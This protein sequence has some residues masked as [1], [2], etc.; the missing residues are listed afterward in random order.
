MAKSNYETANQYYLRAG[1][2]ING[3]DFS[4][5]IRDT[6][7]SNEIKKMA[8]IK[9]VNNVSA[10]KV[11]IPEEGENKTKRI[12]YLR[13]GDTILKALQNKFGTNLDN[14]I[15]AN[16][17]IISFS[18]WIHP[19][20]SATRD[21]TDPKYGVP[22]T[23][24]ENY[25][26]LVFNKEGILINPTSESFVICCGGMVNIFIKNCVIWGS[27]NTLE[28]ADKVN[29]LVLNMHKN[30][31]KVNG[32]IPFINENEEIEGYNKLLSAVIAEDG[33]DY[34][35]S[36]IYL[37]ANEHF[38]K[39]PNSFYDLI[40]RVSNLNEITEADI[41]DSWASPE[42]KSLIVR[43]V[44]TILSE[45]G[46]V[47]FVIPNDNEEKYTIN[48]EKFFE[49]K[50]TSVEDLD[51]SFDIQTEIQDPEG[52][53]YKYTYT[54][55]TLPN[56]T[57]FYVQN[58]ACPFSEEIFIIKNKEDEV[59]VKGKFRAYFTNNSPAYGPTVFNKSIGA[60]FD[61]PLGH[62]D[63]TINGTEEGDRT[64]GLTY[65]DYW[66]HYYP[67]G[68]IKAEDVLV[69]I[70]GIKLT[71]YVNYDIGYAKFGQET[72]SPVI[73]FMID[74]MDTDSYNLINREEYFDSEYD[75]TQVN[76]EYLSEYAT[77]FPIPTEVGHP[78]WIKVVVLPPS[79]ELADYIGPTVAEEGENASNR[80]IF[81]NKGS[82]STVY[83][84]TVEQ[85]AREAS[86]A[87]D[88]A[89]IPYEG[90]I[91][92]QGGKYVANEKEYQKRIIL[93][94]RLYVNPAYTDSQYD[95][96][97]HVV[98]DQCDDHGL[99][100]LITSFDTDGN[101]T[102]ASILSVL[103]AE[104]NVYVTKWLAKMK[105]VEEDFVDEIVNTSGD[106]LTAQ[107]LLV[108]LGLVL[109]SPIEKYI[110]A[111]TITETYTESTTGQPVRYP[112]ISAEFSANEDLTQLGYIGD[113]VVSGSNC[114][115]LASDFETNNTGDEV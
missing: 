110:A 90:F 55:K 12:L 47:N 112:T 49:F 32:S 103:G 41:K 42:Q 18:Q 71:P 11:Y 92:F 37:N 52:K 45:R 40:L 27:S 30:Q 106:M 57:R 9:K 26:Y 36:G 83:Y 56:G 70:N 39:Y 61:I 81:K 20:Y 63:S 46:H 50:S 105:S 22:T 80:I 100:S 17:A 60:L 89:H 79:G 48:E 75:T 69:F 74:H 73:R 35:P 38:S 6:R 64:D 51:L 111:N 24:T 54:L 65:K 114:P 66:K 8:I 87:I 82:N 99:G 16:T 84:P 68:N 31:W 97:V 108:K 109:T 88:F 72:G 91:M 7:I 53:R 59:A 77:S 3:Y 58:R 19:T 96:E 28:F 33:V 67:L 5:G 44:N 13:N 43:A 104:E 86:T 34:L 4:E 113:I 78:V 15:T 94:R 1:V 102:V 76:E 95:M 2:E 23:G 14:Y 93:D 21:I 101:P 85:S 29:I 62:F 25:E 115:G 10:F 107:D 98:I